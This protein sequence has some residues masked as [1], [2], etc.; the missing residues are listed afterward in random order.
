MSHVVPLN[1]TVHPALHSN[2]IPNKEATARIGTMCPLSVVG[3]PGI[4]ISHTC[5]EFTCLP[6]GR[7][8]VKGF[9]AGRMF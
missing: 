2:C 4:L 3:S 7:L 5:V 8:I 9:F 6:S 1:T